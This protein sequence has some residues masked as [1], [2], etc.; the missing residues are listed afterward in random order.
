MIKYTV[1]ARKLEV[2]RELTSYIERKIAKLDRYFPRAHRPVG[3]RIELHRDEAAS[4]DK[5]YVAS[6]HIEVQ[7]PDLHAETATI[8]PHSAIDILEAKLKDQIRKYKEKHVPKRFTLK[9]DNLT[10]TT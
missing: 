3:A 9:R 4:P 2:D 5:R 1:S 6:A 8:N 10:E 7:G